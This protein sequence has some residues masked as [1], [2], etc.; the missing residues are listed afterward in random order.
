MDKTPSMSDTV[1]FLEQSTL[2]PNV[3]LIA[4]VQGIGFFLDGQFALTGQ[5]QLHERVAFVC[6]RSC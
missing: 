5:D 1:R 3:G 4:P 6:S 2:G